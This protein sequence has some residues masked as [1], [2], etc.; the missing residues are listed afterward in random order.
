MT[1]LENLPNWQCFDENEKYLRKFVALK[2]SD[3]S[4]NYKFCNSIF[5]RVDKFF[6]LPLNVKIIY[7]SHLLKSNVLMIPIFCFGLF[8]YLFIYSFFKNLGVFLLYIM[9]NFYS[10]TGYKKHIIIV[11]LCKCSCSKRDIFLRRL[12]IF[13]FQNSQTIFCV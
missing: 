11:F 3:C 1:E 10:G 2:H 4:T 8:I 5:R 9:S 12:S 7:S 6:P 13:D